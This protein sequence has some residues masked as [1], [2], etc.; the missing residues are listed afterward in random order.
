MVQSVL[1]CLQ[2]FL[3]PRCAETPTRTPRTKGKQ[4]SFSRFSLDFLKAA[5]PLYFYMETVKL[6]Q[7][8]L[9]T[10]YDEIHF[11]CML[12]CIYSHTNSLSLFLAKPLSFEVT[13]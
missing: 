7:R 2:V 3:S 1:I 6:T 4:R 8:S 12:L 5:F 10:F 13:H 11:I 9:N